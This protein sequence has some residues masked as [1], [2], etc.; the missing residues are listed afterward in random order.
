MK[1]A[2]IN[3]ERVREEHIFVCRRGEKI[4]SSRGAVGIRFSDRYVDPFV[5]IGVVFFDF[6]SLLFSF[7]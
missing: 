4:L 3:L 5:C 6:F 1:T 7:L 2:K